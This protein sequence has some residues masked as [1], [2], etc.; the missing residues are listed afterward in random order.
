MEKR[1][2]QDGKYKWGGNSSGLEL[3]GNFSKCMFI[4]SPFKE[5]QN[6]S[7][8][9]D[10]KNEEYDDSMIE[11]MK[12]SKYGPSHGLRE[13]KNKL[14]PSDANQRESFAKNSSESEEDVEISFLNKVRFLH[15][16]Y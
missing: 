11:T 2:N 10:D 3:E 12:L 5:I 16:F 8:V 9:A 6:R 4:D 15:S 1:D 14:F 13:L 7:I